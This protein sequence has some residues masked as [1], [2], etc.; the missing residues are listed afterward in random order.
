MDYQ[1]NLLRAK[2][3]QVLIDQDQYAF[4]DYMKII[5]RT[6]GYTRKHVSGLL[7][8]SPHRITF[9]EYGKYGNRGPCH[10]FIA[11]LSNFYGVD[12]FEMLKKF[13]AYMDDAD[14][15]LYPRS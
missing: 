14:R 11:S 3:T 13:Q 12:P 2:L 5:R 7:G 8:C 1:K 4:P 10:E 6:L 9:L 15:N